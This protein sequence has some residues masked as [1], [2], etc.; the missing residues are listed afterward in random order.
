M[1]REEKEEESDDDDDDGKALFAVCATPTHF[2][3]NFL[4]VTV[5]KQSFWCD[6]LKHVWLIYKWRIFVWG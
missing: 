2:I 4:N 3:V 5:F 6:I 1:G